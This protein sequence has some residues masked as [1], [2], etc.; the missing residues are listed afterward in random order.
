M[1][2]SMQAC[3]G[4]ASRDPKL[5]LRPMCWQGQGKA[6]FWFDSR[7][8]LIDYTKAG[9]TGPATTPALELREDEVFDSW[10]CVPL[11]TLVTEVSGERI[12]QP[13]LMPV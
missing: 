13:V 8:C 6:F 3:L 10:Q 12:K 4:M 9:L 5:C 2:T 11:A 1:W 7:L